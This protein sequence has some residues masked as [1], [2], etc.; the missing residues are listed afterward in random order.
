M[1]VLNLPTKEINNS[2]E[3]DIIHENAKNEKGDLYDPSEAKESSSS[4]DSDSNDDE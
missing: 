2:S 4:D 3:L 1:S